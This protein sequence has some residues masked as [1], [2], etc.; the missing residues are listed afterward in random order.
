MEDYHA[1]KPGRPMDPV[2][3]GIMARI[4]RDSDLPACPWLVRLPAT[5]RAG[6]LHAES[7]VLASGDARGEPR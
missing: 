7:K 5:R 2:R 6:T 1:S 4:A 3:S